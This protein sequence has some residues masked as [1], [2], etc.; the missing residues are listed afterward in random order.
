RA[1]AVMPDMFRDKVFISSL[2]RGV[3]LI[4]DQS[5]ENKRG[6]ITQI[7]P[8]L[9][10][11]GG[12]DRLSSLFEAARL[13]VPEG[14]PDESDLQWDLEEDVAEP[15]GELTEEL[16]EVPRPPLKLS[17]DDWN[18]LDDWIQEY[19]RVLFE[20][21]RQEF[22][23]TDEPAPR[24]AE[25]TTE[26]EFEAT[27]HVIEPS[28]ASLATQVIDSS[29]VRVRQFGLLSPSMLLKAITRTILYSK[30]SHRFLFTKGP[31]YRDVIRVQIQD[32]NPSDLV[33]WVAS[34]LVSAG[35]TIEKL[36]DDDEF[37]FVM[38]SKNGL[39]GVFATGVSGT[40]VCSPVVIVGNNRA[41]VVQMIDKIRRAMS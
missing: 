7:R 37:T 20:R 14:V 12:T 24:A 22:S 31:F 6:F 16:S 26:Q 28:M 30:Q 39:R 33:D 9:S 3:A 18:L 27:H 13:M 25:P 15:A 32:M 11:H 41:T 29:K 17:K 40:I 34:G 35:L 10:Q 8:R 1:P 2:P 19:I 36:M 38:F 4:F 23:I 5:T 21:E